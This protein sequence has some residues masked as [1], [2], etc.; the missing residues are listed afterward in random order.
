MSTANKAIARRYFKEIMNGGNAA[1]IDD[2][3]APE[4]S[5][6]VPSYPETYQGPEGMK[7]FIDMLHDAFAD[8]HVEVLEIVAGDEDAVGR[9]RASGIHLGRPVTTVAGEAAPKG[10]SFKIDGMTWLRIKDGKIV[11]AFA[12]EDT[13][14]LLTQ[15]GAIPSRTATTTPA[16][17]IALTRRYFEEV[18]SQGKL[19]VIEEILAPNFAFIIPTQPAPITGYEGIK[20]FVGYLRGAFPDITFTVEREVAE[21]NKVASRWSISG[22]HQGE[23]L[24]IPAS[25]NKV[26][27]HGIDIFTIENGK[28][29]EV[30]VN[31]NDFGLFV[32]LG[33][34]D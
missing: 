23:F 13:V 29:V 33:A 26:I 4:F 32:Q 20:G 9:W 14:G 15:L 3:I 30:Q 28:I 12:N 21:G 10:G 27:D 2:L 25:G 17:N 8:F 6:V 34:F 1:T 31:E 5:I 18:M 19:E 7:R 11:G 22:T 24:G 16:E